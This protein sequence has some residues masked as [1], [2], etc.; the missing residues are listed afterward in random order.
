M[1]TNIVNALG[2][3]SGIDTAS[4]VN[5]LVDAQK[6][7]Q[8]NRLDSK[9]TTLDAQISAYGTLKSS[10]SEFQNLMTPLANPDTFNARSVSL[11]T[12]DIVTANTL[13][14]NA[15]LG[16]YQLEVLEVAQGQSLV[17]N[18]TFADKDAAAGV[19]GTLTIAQGE[20][21]YDGSDNPSSFAENEALK[22]IEIEVTATDSIQEI[23]DKINADSSDVEASVLLVDGSYQLLISAPSGEENALRISGSDS[24]LDF[25][26]FN[27]T[28]HGN[29]T[30][31]QKAQDA[32]ININGLNVK[33]PSNDID[34]VIQGLSLTLNKASPGDKL[35]FSIT[36][37]KETAKTAV[38][39]FIE[40]YNTLYNTLKGL[41]STT[42]DS[43]T[44]ETKRGELATDGTAKNLLSR[45]R[46]MISSTVPGVDEF[47]SLSQVGIRTKLDGTL[48]VD[49]EDFDAA[50]N[51]NFAQVGALFSTTTSSTNS[52]VSVE[53]GSFGDR[54]VAGTYQGTIT[55]A[56]SK[57]FVQGSGMTTTFPPS[58]TETDYTFTINV[59]GTESEE[60]T[61]T[62]TFNSQEELRAGLQS[63]INNESTL[64]EAGQAVDVIIDG[65]ELKIQSRQYGANTQVQFVA[66]GDAFEAVTGLSET[67]VR[68]NGTDVSGTIA[69]DAAFGA[70]DVLLPKIDTDPYGLNLQ[71]Q[72]GASG[73][74]SFSFSRGFAGEMSLL[75][76]GFLSSTGVIKNREDSINNQLED[77]KDDQE[78][79]D[80]KMAI[81]HDRLTSQ[82]VAME[83]ILASFRT[84]S[85]SLNGLVDRLP[86]TASNN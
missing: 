2:A 37:D 23:A 10:L 17:A 77:I 55:T 52:A 74:F 65:G 47:N 68:L 75:I 40:G 5:S 15:Q 20:W 3:G 9:K 85:E 53:V 21:T 28:N 34:D 72:E 13:D 35:T 80:R 86:F 59:N 27:E 18:Q 41:T 24:S 81:M 46:S 67:S 43:E 1:A 19:S 12:T 16:T 84:T 62:G 6:A 82:Y 50:F 36:E 26:N 49:T 54:A 44:N 38:N 48:E 83:N 51:D 29:V 25:L 58:P 8:Q 4:L 30:E 76:D 11:P 70:G 63:L 71:V 32:S 66:A 73:N 42:T 22:A 61:L 64:K 7:P 33:R 56:P 60:L 69:G 57:G 78:E 39:N 31:T 79:L 45:M 14:A